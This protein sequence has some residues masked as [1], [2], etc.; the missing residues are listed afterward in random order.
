VT[1]LSTLLDQER[2]RQARMV[3][4]A[5]R[6][7]RTRERQ[8]Q[9][10]ASRQ[11][12]NSIK[13]LWEFHAHVLTDDELAWLPQITK[14][15]LGT[16]EPAS[17]ADAQRL[18]K[19]SEE[20]WRREHALRARELRKKLQQFGLMAVFGYGDDETSHEQPY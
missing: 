2:K 7:E 17:E 5:Q 18:A 8:K 13:Y 9:R 6:K 15:P 11:W 14:A 4:E 10:W 12:R 1:D 20:V 19:L 16:W 3:G